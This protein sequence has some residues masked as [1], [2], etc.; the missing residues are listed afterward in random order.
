[1]YDLIQATL[2]ALIQST[3]ALKV[4]WVI[5]QVFYLSQDKQ[6]LLCKH[7]D[8]LPALYL[9]CEKDM[10]LER[11]QGAKDSVARCIRDFA[12]HVRTLKEAR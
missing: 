3:K 8:G 6:P 9:N 10:D 7:I 12:D 1:M 2:K 5:S 4:V 11:D